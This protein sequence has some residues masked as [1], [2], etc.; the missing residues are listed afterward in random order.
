[1]ESG[2]RIGLSRVYPTSSG[3]KTNPVDFPSMGRL[4]RALAL[5]TDRLFLHN[6]GH[7]SIHLTYRMRLGR[8]PPNHGQVQTGGLSGSQLFAMSDI[9]RWPPRYAHGFGSH[10]Q[11]GQG[12]L[13]CS[14]AMIEGRLLADDRHAGGVPRERL[15]YYVISSTRG[16]WQ[17]RSARINSRTQKTST[18]QRRLAR[19]WCAARGSGA[20]GRKEAPRAAPFPGGGKFGRSWLNAAAPARCRAERM[21][22]SVASR[23]R[24]PPCFPI[25]EH[26]PQT[27]SIR[28]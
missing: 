1:L 14:R 4:A 16:Q 6:R 21:A 18:G 19:A 23:S 15:P 8:R 22:I 26:D 2:S 25:L 7:R 11:T 12:T 13:I 9:A 27:S 3:L 17:S 24:R 28:A 5:P 10:L 20:L